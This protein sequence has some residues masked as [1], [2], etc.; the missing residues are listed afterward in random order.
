MKAHFTKLKNKIEES[1]KRLEE[2]RNRYG[3]YGSDPNEKYIDQAI[4]IALSNF[5]N[6][7]TVGKKSQRAKLIKSFKN[8]LVFLKEVYPEHELSAGIISQGLSLCLDE[9][10]PLIKQKPIKSSPSIFNDMLKCSNFTP[11]YYQKV[12][13]FF[14]PDALAEYT[15]YNLACAYENKH[16]EMINFFE[17]KVNNGYYQPF[18]F[19]Y[20]KLS[21][22][23]SDIA[24]AA[25]KVDPENFEKF[26]HAKGI[27]F[28]KMA[29]QFDIH[30]NNVI[31]DGF[32]VTVSLSFEQSLI[33]K[34]GSNVELVKFLDNKLN[35][36]KDVLNSDIIIQ[37]RFE[38]KI[39]PEFKSPFLFHLLKEDGNKF[40][41]LYWNNVDWEKYFSYKD[42]YQ[43]GLAFHTADAKVVKLLDEKGYDFKEKDIHGNVAINKLMTI[44]VLKKNFELLDW[45]MEYC[46]KNS[47]DPDKIIYKKIPICYISYKLPLEKNPFKDPL[48]N[49]S[50]AFKVDSR[51]FDNKKVK[52]NNVD[53]LGNT[54]GHSLLRVSQFKNLMLNEKNRIMEN[55]KEILDKMVKKKMDVNIVN[56]EGNS[57]FTS[58]LTLMSSGSGMKPKVVDYFIKNYDWDKMPGWKPHH[59]FHLLKVF[60]GPNGGRDILNMD[61]LKLTPEHWEKLFFKSINRK[62]GHEPTAEALSQKAAF[63]QRNYDRVIWMKNA[64]PT[65]AAYNGRYSKKY[66]E[67]PHFFNNDFLE[68][69]TIVLENKLLKEVKQNSNNSQKLK[70]L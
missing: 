65:M 43:R 39:Y 67:V 53:H 23:F 17:N 3:S 66:S 38:E 36:Y 15:Y 18:P 5:Q 55:R 47:I 20:E 52:I 48:S 27:N 45:G 2:D 51:I 57:V 56:H 10:V 40:H 28:L 31:A 64:F 4:N 12:E 25:K 42:K 22:G 19:N 34:I 26:F 29:E 8:S 68:R 32:R 60:A 63:S 24:V 41:E 35:F 21:Q 6:I 11:E 61:D 69:I 70:I 13:S 58:W 44:A 33:S 46:K 62:H 7:N 16:S 30:R 37:K 54:I 1:A 14:A 50:L 59:D 49:Q 9:I